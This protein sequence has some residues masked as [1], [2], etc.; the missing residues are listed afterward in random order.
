[1][2]AARKSRKLGRRTRQRR[3][4]EKPNQFLIEEKTQA[5]QG[6]AYFFLSAKR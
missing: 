1:M 5:K 2:K 4:K 3:E 6:R